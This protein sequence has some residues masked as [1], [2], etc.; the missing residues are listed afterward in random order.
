M[1]IWMG[2]A[3]VTMLV[4]WYLND[5]SSLLSLHTLLEFH[6]SILQIVLGRMGI[7]FC[8]GNGGMPHQFLHCVQINTIL[9]QP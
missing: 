2:T 1:V 5:L 9:H 7:T 6:H 3:D 8:H 4:G